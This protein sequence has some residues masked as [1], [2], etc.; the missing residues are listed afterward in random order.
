MRDT[1]IAGLSVLI[2]SA[3]VSMLATI[4]LAILGY[5]IEPKIYVAPVAI[6]GLL[7]LA[8]FFWYIQAGLI[9][10]RL[11]HLNLVLKTIRDVN[12][13][14]TK[15]KDRDLLIQGICDT[16]VENRGY[17]NA[18]IALKN[19]LGEW[20]SFTESG[21]SEEFK[22]ILDRLRKG[23]LIACCQK[24]L[25]QSEIV[26]ID[27]PA[28]LCGDCPL[29][30]SYASQGAL[31]SRLE[32]DGKVYGMMTLSIVKELATDAEEQELVSE[33]ADDIAFG[34]HNIEVQE[35]REKTEKDLRISMDA[36]GERIKELNC[37]FGVSRLVEKRHISLDELFQGI[38]D[39]IPPAWQYPQITCTRLN[40]NQQEFKSE[41]FRET[42]WRLDKEIIV[43]NRPAGQITVCYL[44]EMPE[45][46]EGPF[47]A[48]EKNLIDALAERLGR[49]I[50]RKKTEEALQASE[51]R[52][53]RLVENSLAGIS[54]V[55]DTQVVYQNKE[56]ERLLGPLPRSYILGDY[57]N[58]HP[59]DV[60]KVRKLSQDITTGK[61]NTL[62][63]DFRYA[64]KGDMAN[65]IWIHCRAHKIVFRQRESILFNLMD[66]TQIKELEKLLL[67]QD[68]MASLGRVAAG[69]AH[70]IRN[71]LSGINIYLNTLEKFFRRGEN[72]EKVKDVFQHLLSA[73]RKIESV[74]RRVMDFSKPSEP[75]FIVAD[76]NQSIYEAIKL[77]SVTLRKSG[78]KLEKVLTDDLPKCRLD[79]QQI[80]EVIL[81]L[82][83][84]A[85]DAMRSMVGEK[86]IKVT[87]SANDKY[88]TVKVLDSGPGI[89]M[90]NKDTV[91]DPF[92]TTKSDSTGIG[93]SIC[94][95]IIADHGGK[96]D[97]QTSK[98]GGA[99]FCISIPVV[100]TQTE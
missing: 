13:L 69:I 89:L 62:D 93:L 72:E 10:K 19:E 6:G 1:V 12:H 18:W 82:L 63:A 24:A 68:K 71:P 23:N 46:D 27:E 95:R 17:N 8:Y 28:T 91:F 7:G 16:L 57:N 2:G 70:E 4:Y 96:I 60:E 11:V 36:L 29:A 41:N 26:A 75:N 21:L 98:W 30:A 3:A 53:R 34:L 84:N 44:E 32:F 59:D 9:K 56:Q 39:L 40:I 79:P 43:N 67:I 99:E 73:S 90:E 20:E 85:A 42:A 66:M 74:I 49:I 22:P 31:S 33:I 54:I 14:L 65:S 92:F 48:E 47:L 81:N 38:V 35:E 77:T 15:E 94:H 88:V 78:I 87:S 45:S 64:P 55:Q 100:V 50:E 61:I 83:N 37:L 86:K 58:I 25:S 51:K 97:V 52:F 80:E 5:A 76:I